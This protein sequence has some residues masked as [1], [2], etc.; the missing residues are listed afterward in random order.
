[1]LSLQIRQIRQQGYNRSKKRFKE[2]FCPLCLVLGDCLEYSV[3]FFE[4]F[5]GFPS[6]G[7]EQHW[8]MLPTEAVLVSTL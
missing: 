2:S 8:Q 1:M 4:P 5:W 7:S 6:V 3:Q